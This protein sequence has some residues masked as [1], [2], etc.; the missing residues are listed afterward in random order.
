MAPTP[1][2][3]IQSK[4]RYPYT[5]AAT[6]TGGTTVTYSFGDSNWKDKLT[7]YDGKGIAYNAIGNPT[8]YDGWSYTWEGRRLMGMARAAG[9]ASPYGAVTVSGS[10]MTVAHTQGAEDAGD[11]FTVDSEGNLK[12]TTSKAQGAYFLEEGMLKAG[13]GGGAQNV[14]YQYNADGLRV[15]KTAEGITTTTPSTAS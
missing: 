4:A 8:A 11:T 2:G 9:G 3:N 10:T 12:V 5:T 13:Q 7:A 6:P 15:S 14:S 1:G